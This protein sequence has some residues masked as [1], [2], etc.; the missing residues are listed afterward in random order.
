[1]TD[2]ATLAVS[3]GRPVANGMLPLESA[4]AAIAVAT[5]RARREGTLQGNGALDERL[6]IYDDLLALS[7]RAH[8]ER[9]NKARGAI[10]AMLKPMIDKNSPSNVLLAEAFNVNADNDGALS[11]EEVREI[12]AT[13]VHWFLQRK[14]NAARR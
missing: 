10:R 12:T 7:I 1:M 5:E 2:P 4:R 11:E 9:M 6:A 14:R 13:E 3:L 8:E